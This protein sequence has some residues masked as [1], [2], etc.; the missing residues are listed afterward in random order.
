VFVELRRQ[1]DIRH[2][3][4]RQ[5][6][7][8]TSDIEFTRASQRLHGR[9][10]VEFR[11]DYELRVEVRILRNVP[12]H[13]RDGEIELVVQG[14]DFAQCICRSEILDGR[15]LRYHEARGV[16]EG[17]C[18]PLDVIKVKYFQERRVSEANALVE[19]VGA[20]FH[21]ELD[22][23]RPGNR[24]DIGQLRFEDRPYGGLNRI[25]LLETD[26]KVGR[27]GCAD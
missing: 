8:V 16:F 22:F 5:V 26:I 17:G 12:N 11:V 25:K 19:A 21:E 27:G 15:R 24:F 1:Q 9:K 13:G 10:Y 18:V 14:N 3:A 7:P 6:G 23:D 20:H 4:E 2:I